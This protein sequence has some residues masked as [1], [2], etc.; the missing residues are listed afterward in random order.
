MNIFEFRPKDLEY[1]ELR[2]NKLRRKDINFK[3]KNNKLLNILKMLTT[4]GVFIAVINTVGTQINVKAKSI[5]ISDASFV[6]NIYKNDTV[7]VTFDL[8]SLDDHSIVL[9]DQKIKTNIANISF[10]NLKEAT[11]YKMIF[12]EF[13][14]GSIN[15]LG[16]FE[17]ITN[18]SCCNYVKPGLF[19]NNILDE[20]LV[21]VTPVPSVTSTLT[22][23]PT[24][25]PTPKTT[26][27]TTP[28]PDK[29]PVPTPNETPNPTPETTPVP[30]PIVTSPTEPYGD[31]LAIVDGF[32]EVFM[33][34]DEE[35]NKYISMFFFEMYYGTATNV[36]GEAILSNNDK[37]TFDANYMKNK[38]DQDDTVIDV[39]SNTIFDLNETASASLTMYFTLNGTNYQTTKI[40]LFDQI[41]TSTIDLLTTDVIEGLDGYNLPLS[42]SFTIYPY[43][44]NTL[45]ISEVKFIV[46]DENNNQISEIILTDQ[47]YEIIDNIDLT[48]TFNIVNYQISNLT[49][50]NY[51]IDFEIVI[52]D[53]VYIANQLNYVRP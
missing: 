25:V 10:E 46:N 51:N 29:T 15:F 37:F 45:D 21:V 23:N 34:Y 43:T 4:A 8:M 36:S 14:D 48:K 27:T 22:P 39:T 44:G 16:S 7:D 33:E 11:K 5:G 31:S 24:P 47:D 20:Q 17:F 38:I 26:P 12:R 13:N 9:T 2:N 42:T 50:T 18:S 28:T 41:K 53:Q 40:I 1:G 49:L 3:S 35:N 6:V 19:N 32:T 30:T 52:N